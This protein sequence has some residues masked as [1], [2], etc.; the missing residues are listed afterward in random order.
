MYTQ[1]CRITRVSVLGQ[2]GRNVRWVYA[3]LRPAGHGERSLS[4]G[5]AVL[6]RPIQADWD[7]G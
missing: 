1:R 2:D 6:H 7:G 5:V 3:L 4:V